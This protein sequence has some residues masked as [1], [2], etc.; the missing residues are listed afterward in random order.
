[1]PLGVRATSVAS[2]AASGITA[3]ACASPAYWPLAALMRFLPPPLDSATVSSSVFQAPQPGHLPSQR[4]L[5]AP[6]SVQV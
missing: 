6:H 4:G 2:M 3:W 5:V 1:M